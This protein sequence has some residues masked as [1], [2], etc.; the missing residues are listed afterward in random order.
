QLVAI[1]GRPRATN[2]AQAR[3]ERTPAEALAAALSQRFGASI[4]PSSIETTT[5]DNGEQRFLLAG[6]S[7]FHMSEAAPVRPVMFPDGGRLV[8]AY[9]TEFYA[10]LIDSVDAEAFR[11]VVAADDGRVLERRDLTVSEKK[12]PPSSPPPVDFLY[13]VY[14]EP[15]NQRP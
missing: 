1:S 6:G 14:A 11:Y 13:R 9:V 10:G 12:N 5:A 2:D 3:F 8:A 4:S 15:S 7:S